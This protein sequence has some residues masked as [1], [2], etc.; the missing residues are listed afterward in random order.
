VKQRDFVKMELAPWDL[1]HSSVAAMLN[2]ALIAVV[3]AAAAN[4]YE[5]IGQAAMPWELSFLVVPM[6]FHEETRTA[7]PSRVD[8]YLPK[9][10]ERNPIVHAGLAPRARSTAPYV[11]EGIRY[12]L[13]TQAL[14]LSDAGLLQGTLRGRMPRKNGADTADIVKAA[15]FLGRWFGT[16]GSSATVFSVLGVTP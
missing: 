4:R 1:R 3:V 6:A 2:P 14:S 15:A 11:R 5:T 12:G 7:I 16:M 9:W 8:S 13:R 10:V